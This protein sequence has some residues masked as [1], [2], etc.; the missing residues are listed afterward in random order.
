MKIWEEIGVEEPRYKR[1]ASGGI[2]PEVTALVKEWDLKHNPKQ[3][4][5]NDPKR[6]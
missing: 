1:W 4:K 3:S 5:K 6:N 2:D